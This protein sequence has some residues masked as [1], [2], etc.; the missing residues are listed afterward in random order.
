[1]PDLPSGNAVT[2][3]QDCPQITSKGLTAFKDHQG[4]T[5]IYIS[6]GERFT[7]DGM[8]DIAQLRN[9]TR[10]QLFLSHQITDKGIEN[11]KELKNLEFL[12]L[13]ETGISDQGLKVL[14]AVP[15]NI[16]ETQITDAGLKELYA[17]KDLKTLYVENNDQ[18]TDEGCDELQKQLPNVDISR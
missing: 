15:N 9:L 18:I 3:P 16:R 12:E 7:D 13:G 4:L 5:G 10:L 17:L 11:L 1:M 8:K 6:Q 14:R 2:L